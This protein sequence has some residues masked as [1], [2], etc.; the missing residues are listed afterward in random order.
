MGANKIL[1][2]SQD[3]AMKIDLLLNHHLKLYPHRNFI[4]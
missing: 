3:V 4:S 2:F 1:T